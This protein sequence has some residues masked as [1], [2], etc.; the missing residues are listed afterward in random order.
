MKNINTS[1]PKFWIYKTIYY[2]PQ[3]GREDEYRDRRY[4]PK[5]EKWGDRNN[6][7]ET[8]DGCGI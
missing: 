7:I 4:D 6:I 5:P 8:W 2:C 3:C 1:K